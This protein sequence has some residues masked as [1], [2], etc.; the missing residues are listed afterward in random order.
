[1]ACMGEMRNVYE[2]LLIK[3]QGKIP[4]GRPGC[5]WENNI[6]NELKEIGWEGLN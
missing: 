1:M 4:L 5:R 6:Q 3:P 2:V